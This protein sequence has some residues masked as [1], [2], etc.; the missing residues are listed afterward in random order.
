MAT[1]DSNFWRGGIDVS[2]LMYLRSPPD[3]NATTVCTALGRD[4][5]SA[6]SRETEAI[7]QRVG[8]LSQL[9]CATLSYRGDA[10]GP[11]SV[12]VNCSAA[13]EQSLGFACEFALSHFTRPPVQV[14]LGFGLA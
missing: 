11:K 14:D 5:A 10:R 2:A 12:V 7:G 6:A 4:P 3:L 8:V 13:I 9:A 1:N